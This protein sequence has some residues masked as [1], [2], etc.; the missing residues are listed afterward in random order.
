MFKRKDKEKGQKQ[1]S[2]C[3]CSENFQTYNYLKK[4]T[5]SRVQKA[6][7]MEMFLRLC[8]KY[9]TESSAAAAQYHTTKTNEINCSQDTKTAGM[10]S[11]VI[12]FN[13]LGKS[14]HY[15]ALL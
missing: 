1:P 9:F 5:C 8:R 12:D 6:Q 14:L 15:Q 11:C 4:W 3:L 7:N 2:Q 10:H 13:F